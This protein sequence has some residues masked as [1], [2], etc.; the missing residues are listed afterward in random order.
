MMFMPDSRGQESAPFELLVAVIVMTFVIAAGLG[1]TQFLMQEQCKGE[2][3]SQMEQIKTAIETVAKGRG[4]ANVSFTMPS[5]FRP[6]ESPSC[7]YASD[8]NASRLCIKDTD[9]KQ[10]CAYYCGGSQRSCTL[11]IF[12]SPDY[13]NISCLRISPLTQFFTQSPCE[14]RTGWELQDWMANSIQQGQYSL[15]NAFSLAN[16]NPYVCAYR[17]VNS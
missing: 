11:L 9:S 17:R 12:T 2:M 1:A 7:S 3:G 8:P 5:C 4:K 14:E 13:S 6:S 16:D 10:T 15:V